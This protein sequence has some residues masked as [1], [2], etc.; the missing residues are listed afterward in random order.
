MIK[1]LANEKQTRGGKVFLRTSRV[2]SPLYSFYSS[3]SNVAYL[4][5]AEL[6]KAQTN[7]RLP[8]IHPEFIYNAPSSK[9]L[10]RFNHFNRPIWKSNSYVIQFLRM[11]CDYPWDGWERYCRKDTRFL[12]ATCGFGLVGWWGNATS[13]SQVLSIKKS[14]VP[15]SKMMYK[16]TGCCVRLKIDVS[17]ISQFCSSKSSGVQPLSI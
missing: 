5:L 8:I 15:P 17:D 2:R 14:N 1:K 3:F 9:R 16:P 7:S 11:S 6:Y 12:L 13:E 4:V 10:W